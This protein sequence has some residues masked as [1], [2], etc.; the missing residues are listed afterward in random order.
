VILIAATAEEGARQALDWGRFSNL[1]AVRSH[2]VF[3]VDP[4]LLGRMAPRI[5]QGVREVCGL[6]DVARGGPPL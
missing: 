5:L 3:T 1:G 4:S 6:L 2:H